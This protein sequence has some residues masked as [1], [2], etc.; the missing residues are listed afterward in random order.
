MYDKRVHLVVHSHTLVYRFLDFQNSVKN[1][2]EAEE[3][4]CLACLQLNLPKIGSSRSSRA[5]DCW[6]VCFDYF[7][8]L[9][10]TQATLFW[11]L[12]IRIDVSSASNRAT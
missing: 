2:L 4:Y 5:E 8:K 3:T 10:F 11:T 9:A 1:Q 7:R 6:Q 12:G